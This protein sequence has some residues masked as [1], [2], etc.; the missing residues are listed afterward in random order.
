MSLRVTATD[1]AGNAGTATKTI[2]VTPAAKKPK[3]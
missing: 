2:K 1:A 3:R